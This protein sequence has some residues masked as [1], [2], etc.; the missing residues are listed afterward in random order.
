MACLFS[1]TQELINEIGNEYGGILCF[2]GV[3]MLIKKQN[4]KQSTHMISYPTNANKLMT[5][6]EKNGKILGKKKKNSV[7]KQDAERCLC[8]L[9]LLPASPRTFL[10]THIFQMKKDNFEK[11]CI[12]IILFSNTFVWAIASYQIRL[13]LSSSFLSRKCNTNVFQTESEVKVN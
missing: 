6:W 7:W 13:Y 8:C 4:K 3:D 1:K 2:S 11:C 12:K 10:Q 5:C 9:V